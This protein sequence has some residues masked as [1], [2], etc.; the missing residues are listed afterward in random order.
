MQIQLVT[1]E[2]KNHKELEVEQV[3]EEKKKKDQILN[4]IKVPWM[5]KTT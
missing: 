1:E 3:N 5:A 2:G 4:V